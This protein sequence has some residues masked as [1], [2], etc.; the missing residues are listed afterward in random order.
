[1]LSVSN[2]GKSYGDQVLFSGVNF[3]VDAGDRIAVI[4][5]NGSGKT[6]L[7]DIIVKKM[8]P[9]TGDVVMRK[10]SSIGYLQQDIWPSSRKKL[11]EEVSNASTRITGLA[12]RI[13]A[14]QEELAE[15]RIKED[16]ERLLLELGELQHSFEAAG[17]YEIEH[18]ARGVLSGLGFAEADF[19]RPL[20]N[21]SGGW[22]MRAELA[23]L[24][25][26][27][28]D[29]L[30]LDEPTNHLDIE[31]CIW[32][33]RYLET[34]Q[35][36]VMVTSHDRE[37]LNRVASK[38]LAFEQDGMILRRGNYDSFITARQ[39]ELETKQAAARRQEREIKREMRFIERFRAKNTKATQVQSRIKRLEKMGRVV[40]PRATKRMRFSFP[41][42]PRSGRDVITLRHV[43]KAY[44][45]NEVYRDLNLVLN[46]GDRVSLVGPN[47]AGKTTLLKILAGVLPFERGECEPGHNVITGYYAQYQLELLNPGNHILDELRQVAPD[48]PEEKLRRILGAFL[49]S[50]DDVYKKVSVLSGGEKARVALAKILTQPTNFLLMDE[51]TNHLDIPSREILTD[52]LEAYHGTLCFITHDR[53]LIR[54]I[55]NK[56]IEIREGRPQVFFGNYDSYMYQKESMARERAEPAKEVKTRAEEGRPAGSRR[57]RK[58]IEAELRNRYYRESASVRKRIGELEA[59]LGRLEERLEEAESLFADEEHYRDSGQVVGAIEEHRRLREA[60]RRLTEEWERLSVEAER[61]KREFEE[62]KSN[63]T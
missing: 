36:A 32:F 35:R 38:V 61:M 31:A 41:E 42:P 23:K 40:V 21:F 13:Q 62:E 34:Y 30:L 50:G 19:N 45:S 49:F 16:P 7:F 11:L 44:D 5:P 63:I 26:L 47:G 54:Q 8:A 29:L 12:D 37:F 1:M 43:F 20:S 24:L 46:R 3:T 22:L 14:I 10:D 55:A 2:I 53:T 59:E 33:E 52:A 9:D 56:V 51:P 39:K 17:G 27:N 57:Q 25:L 60:M 6:T 58:L 4:G 15:K 28:P 48:E 18:R